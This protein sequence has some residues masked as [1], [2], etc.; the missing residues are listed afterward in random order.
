MSDLVQAAQV[1]IMLPKTPH[2]WKSENSHG[3]GRR[4]S[5]RGRSE[6]ALILFFFFSIRFAA[7][8]WVFLIH[9]F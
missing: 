9:I 6:E 1:H 4:K 3:S 8:N 7:F 5:E 2:R